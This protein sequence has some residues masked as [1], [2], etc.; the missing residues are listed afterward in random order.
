MTSADASVREAG[1]NDAPAVGQVQALVWQE[2]YDGIVPPEV[3]AVFDPQSFAAAW[4]DS[5]RNPPEGVHR[6][7]VG[8]AGEQVI[9]FVAT[10]PSQDPDAGQ[11]TGEITALGVHPGARRQ[12]HGSRLV[13]AA[14]DLLREAGAEHLAVWCL[15]EHESVRAFLTDA[16]LQPDGAFR[17]RVISPEG[18]TAREVRLVATLAEGEPSPAPPA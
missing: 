3:H 8:R 7:L 16:G 18:A 14:V 4:R 9:G 1:V 11:T 5:L 17:D 15:V 12:G 2:A 13:N 10:G 6:L